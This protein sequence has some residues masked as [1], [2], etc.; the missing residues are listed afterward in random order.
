MHCFTGYQLLDNWMISSSSYQWRD[1]TT[2]RKGE[3][4]ALINKM[5]WRSLN[6]Q[7][8]LFLWR[9]GNRK[10][11]GLYRHKK[12][13]FPDLK[14]A[15]AVWLRLIWQ[16]C[17][18]DILLQMKCIF[19]CHIASWTGSARVMVENKK[20][21]ATLGFFLFADLLTTLRSTTEGVN[22]VFSNLRF[23]QK[24]SSVIIN[25]HVDLFF[26]TVSWRSSSKKG[27][28]SHNWKKGVH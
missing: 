2:I 16:A 6:T 12:V 17:F 8:I 9:R 5:I 23:P 14:F 24:F 25:M 15:V 18:K 11:P 10:L 27:T 21:M 7:S 3:K 1:R 19:H 28:P 22:K 13:W 4:N 20:N 26:P